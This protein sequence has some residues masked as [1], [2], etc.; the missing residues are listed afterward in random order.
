MV[1][2]IVFVVYCVEFYR[3]IMAGWNSAQEQKIAADL[4]FYLQR[5]PV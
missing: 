2:H 5:W 1:A 3:T 4:F